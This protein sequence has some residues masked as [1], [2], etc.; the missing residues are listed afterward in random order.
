MKVLSID[1]SSKICAVA[2]LEKINEDIKVLKE[3]AQDNGLT[4]SETLMTIIKKVLEEANIELKDIDLIVCDKGPGSFTGIRIGVA[5]AK[6]FSDS[7]N[8]PTIGIS[9]LE[10][11]AHNVSEQGTICSLIDARNDSAYWAVFEKSENQ[12][13]LKNEFSADNISVILEKT[14]KY[15]EIVFVGDGTETYKNDI[16]NTLPKSRFINDNDLSAVSI[17]IA[18]INHFEKNDK[19]DLLPLYIRKPQAERMLE[20]RKN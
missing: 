19:S 20:K 14:S 7:L 2:V 10:A 3:I 6:A 8:I 16:L 13:I 17:G 9:S 11:L 4:H 12:Y 18:G 5:T 1:T 15:K